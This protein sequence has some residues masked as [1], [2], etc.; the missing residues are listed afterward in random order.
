MTRP[1]DGPVTIF[2]GTFNRLDTLR[3]S[4]DSLTRL[5][6]PH[7]VVIVDNGTDHPECVALLEQLAARPLVKKVYPLGKVFS[8]QELTDN[9]N[10]AVADQ[11]KAARKGDWFA[12]TDADISFEA[13][14]RRSIEA[15][16]RVAKATGCAAGPHTRVDA[17]IPHGYP[18]RTRVLATEA[19]LLYRDS[20]LW[21]KRTPY[22]HWPIDTT[23]HLFPARREFRRL[24]F[25]TVRVG[26]PYDAMHLDWYLDVFHPSEENAIYINTASAVGSWGRNWIAGFW[27]AFQ[28][29]QEAAFEMMLAEPR[30]Q[31]DDLCIASFILSWCYQMGVGC[32]PDR[33]RSERE[34]RAA[35]PRRFE[36]FWANEADWLTM[37]Y[38]DD[39]SCLGWLA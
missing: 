32:E 27:Q 30:N 28:Q 20:M 26:P 2:V 16:L 37:I 22:S 38:E 36:S 13:S 15:Y 19:R 11:Y 7:E 25:N 24:E 10:V 9:Y 31:H 3:R 6:Y 18:L 12:I 33:E 17:G 23:F 4:I 21:Q 34:L 8:M 1:A 39:F 35:I 29:G 14:S 5:T